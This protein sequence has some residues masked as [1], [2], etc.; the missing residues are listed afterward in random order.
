MFLSNLTC[1]LEEGC[2]S[3]SA[4]DSVGG[5]GMNGAFLYSPSVIEKSVTG[6]KMREVSG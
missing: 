4:Y 3:E 5:V 2:L 6:L 1:A